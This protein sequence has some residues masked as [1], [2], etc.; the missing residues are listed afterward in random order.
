M[1]IIERRKIA[2][3]RLSKYQ[4]MSKYP[5]AVLDFGI[6]GHSVE[7]W[8]VGGNCS[9]C[10]VDQP[11]NGRFYNC[12]CGLCSLCTNCIKEHYREV[13]EDGRRTHGWLKWRKRNLKQE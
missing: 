3:G 1:T 6:P 4:I 12:E 11:K 7:W 8:I 9:Q 10:P 2:I 5:Q 13:K